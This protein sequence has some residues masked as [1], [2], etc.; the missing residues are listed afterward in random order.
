MD[1]KA[2]IVSPMGMATL[3]NITEESQ[4]YLIRKA[5]GQ[6]P[7]VLKVNDF[8][9]NLLIWYSPAFI[10]AVSPLGTTFLR[11]SGFNGPN[12][13][14]GDIVLTGAFSSLNVRGNTQPRNLNPIPKGLTEKQIDHLTRLAAST[15]LCTCI[16]CPSRRQ[17]D[18]EQ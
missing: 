16:H 9:G 10:G 1:G 17:S 14:F 5:V 2:L 6:L 13:V 11:S 18:V 15:C 3:I 8:D 4:E 7:N 12:P